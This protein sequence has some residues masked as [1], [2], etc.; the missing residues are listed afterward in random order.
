MHT[1]GVLIAQCTVITLW[2][3]CGKFLCAE[4]E[5]GVEWVDCIACNLNNYSIPAIF[6]CT[7]WRGSPGLD[8]SLDSGLDWTMDW[9]LNWTIGVGV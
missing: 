2:S 1:S 6:N 9:T 7:K 8:W 5:T 4:Q 3:L